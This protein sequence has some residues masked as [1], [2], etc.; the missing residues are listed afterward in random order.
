MKC[1]NCGSEKLK[2][3][4]AEITFGRGVREPVRVSQDPVATVCLDCGG[5]QF[6]VPE[7]EVVQLR[8][9]IPLRSLRRIPETLLARSK[10]A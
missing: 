8:D 2:N 9:G 4:N 1:T 5:S 10:S 3:Y 7:P 6:V